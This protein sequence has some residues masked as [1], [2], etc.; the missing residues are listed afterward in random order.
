MEPGSGSGGELVCCY[1]TWAVIRHGSCKELHQE[2]IYDIRLVTL[3]YYTIHHSFACC[4]AA[5]AGLEELEFT[6]TGYGAT[7]Y[8]GAAWQQ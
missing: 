2:V 7:G 4:G 1:T 3:L 8:G 5:V 6:G